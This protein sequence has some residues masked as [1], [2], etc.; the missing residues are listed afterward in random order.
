MWCLPIQK[1]SKLLCQDIAMV[2]KVFSLSDILLF[3]ST[4]QKR[5]RQYLDFF[6]DNFYCILY[7][8]LNYIFFSMCTVQCTYPR[9]Y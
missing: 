9:M 4:R 8:L 7:K 3:F 6:V 2:A 5:K 1:L